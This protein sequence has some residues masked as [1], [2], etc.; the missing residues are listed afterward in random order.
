MSV[1][2]AWEDPPHSKFCG[3]VCTLR[4]KGAVTAE[5]GGWG[6]VGTLLGLWD[7]RRRVIEKIRDFDKF[8]GGQCPPV[9]AAK[10]YVPSRIERSS[11][12]VVFFC[13]IFFPFL[14]KKSFRK[15]THDLFSC[16]GP[17]PGEK[18][19][20]PKMFWGFCVLNNNGWKS[21]GRSNIYLLIN[22][23]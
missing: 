12:P 3:Y 17:H 20:I 16:V 6:H 2:I 21:G 15:F 13:V 8:L 18:D 23:P 11:P 19:E 22:R 14:E 7:L 1:S 10:E 4:I 5:V 9:S